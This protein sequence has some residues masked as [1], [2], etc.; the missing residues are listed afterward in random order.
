MKEDT[1]AQSDSVLG[2]ALAVIR[3]QFLSLW[4]SAFWPYLT[5]AVCW[6]SYAFGIHAHQAA[7]SM[8]NP[9]SLW[10]S[11]GVLGKIGVYAAFVSSVFLPRDLATAGVTMVVWADLQGDQVSL[12]QLVSR[13][14]GIFPRLLILSLAIG[15]ACLIA[16][17]FLAVPGIVLSALTALVIPVLATAD[18]KVRTALKTGLKLSFREFWPLFMLSLAFAMVS[19]LMLL[20]FGAVLV[21]LGSNSDLPWWAGPT[22]A[23][24]MLVGLFPFAMVG[25]AAV[26]TLLYKDGIQKQSGPAAIEAA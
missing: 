25:S 14:G 20:A 19:F 1:V 2:Q 26:T 17:I 10:D 4:L 6:L 9:I 18:T 8:G 15:V 22:S 23:W 16:G 7:E 21:N 12:R 11:L 5:L 13:M 24:A 3:K